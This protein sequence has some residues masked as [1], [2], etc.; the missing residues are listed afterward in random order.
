[1]EFFRESQLQIGFVISQA[2]LSF[3]QVNKDQLVEFTNRCPSTSL[4]MHCQRMFATVLKKEKQINNEASA[5][6]F[7]NSVISFLFAVLQ[8]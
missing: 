8:H 6:L 3:S 1:M 2:L 5:V 4:Q 7:I